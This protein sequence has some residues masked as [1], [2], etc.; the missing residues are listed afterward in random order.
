MAMVEKMDR[1]TA[2]GGDPRE[3]RWSS[4]S[5]NS[6]DGHMVRFGGTISLSTSTTHSASRIPEQYHSFL[7]PVLDKDEGQH[8][9]KLLDFIES[10]IQIQGGI[11]DDTEEGR[12]QWLSVHSDI[13]LS[14][15]KDIVSAWWGSEEESSNTIS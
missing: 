1:F 7:L 8:K 3:V 9:N 6:N 12:K 4:S 13:L 5:N 2:I 14:D 11:S 15:A 10:P